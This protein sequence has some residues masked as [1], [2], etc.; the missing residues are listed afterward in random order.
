MKNIIQ[1][2]LAF[3]LMFVVGSCDLER[4]PYDEIPSENIGV[5]DAHS[6]TL[7]HYAN[8]KEEYYYKTL[9]Y[10]NEYGGDNVSMSGTTS[11]K[12]LNLYKYQRILNN[13]YTENIWKFTYQS[14]ISINRLLET[15]E[16]GQSTDMDQLLG[17]NYFLRGLMYFSLNTIFGRPYVQS[18]E[19][20]LGI[21]LKLTS[22][23]DDYPQRATVKEVYD[24][25]VKDLEK[26]AS[27]MSVKKQNIYA[28]KEAAYALLSRIHLYMQN[29]EKAKE[30]ADQVINSGR[31][32]LLEGSN[33]QRYPRFVPESNTETIFAIRMMKDTDFVKYHMEKYSVGSLYAMINDMG[34]GEVYP[35]YSYLKLLNQHPTDLRHGFIV[36]QYTDRN[37]DQMIYVIE[38]EG[39]RSYLY[40]MVEVK[41]EEGDYWIMEDANHY[42]SPKV[43]KETTGENTLYYVVRNDDG[44]KYYVNIERALDDR[45]GYPKRF[46]YK[47]SLQE[48]QSHLYSPV[49]LRLAEVYLNRAEANYHLNNPSGAIADVNVI[50]RRAQIPLRNLN[51]LPAG[52]SVLD[53]VLEERRLEMAFEGHRKLDIFRY[54]Q[55]LNRKYPG[56]HLSGDASSIYT[57]IEPTDRI[58]VEYIPQ[59]EMDAY[60]TELI[61]NP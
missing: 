3:L 7:G 14:V 16:E 53:W 18:P 52:V 37:Y 34:W 26:A 56:Y 10:V 41:F 28:T 20:N 29:W 45:F 31:F 43:Q 9:H 58:I 36:D 46:V 39:A 50:R 25:A 49:L 22:S 8:M 57:T 17:E 23:M 47:C 38:N 51:D 2:L 19:T 24:Q 15:I 54:N 55:P 48:E 21:P 35:S 44:K 6:I 1:I 13:N 4:L 12:C 5:N 11:D 27:L 32:T 61:Q 59:K 40:K 33:Y 60:P 42:S 30:C